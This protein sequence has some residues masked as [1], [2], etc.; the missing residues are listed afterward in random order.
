MTVSEQKRGLTRK[1]LFNLEPGLRAM[2][3]LNFGV[4]CL[5]MSAWCVRSYWWADGAFVRL[6]LSS[7]VQVHAGVGRMTVWIEDDPLPY[8]FR[9]H[10]RWIKDRTRPEPGKRIPLFHVGFWPGMIRIYAAHWLLAVVAGVLAAL[11]W[12]PRG[13]RWRT[14]LTGVAC[15][16][17]AVAIIAWLDSIV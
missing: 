2:I 7:H 9:H 4:I 12:C 14:I 1:P 8:Q 11:P 5:A 6:G 13:L 10:S 16:V 15:C 17:A 3:S